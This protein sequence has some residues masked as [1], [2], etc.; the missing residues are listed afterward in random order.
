[1]AGRTYLIIGNGAL[2]TGVAA[3]LHL[4]GMVPRLLSRR[5][6]EAIRSRVEQ[7]PLGD[8][9]L[10]L[11]ELS[12][13]EASQAQAILVTVKAHQ[14]RLALLQ[15]LP[16]LPKSAPIISL[17]N[18][19]IDEELK[20]LSRQFP[21]RKFRWGTTTLAVTRLG[22]SVF[23][24]RNPKAT[25]TWGPLVPSEDD[26]LE[27]ERQLLTH[28]PSL[29]RWENDPITSGRR[30]WLFN[31]V[32]NSL[33]ASESAPTNGSLLLHRERLDILFQEAFELG[34]LHWGPWRQP[35]NELFEQLLD[36]IEKTHDNEN[37]MA[38]DIRLGKVTETDFLAGIARRYPGFEMLKLLQ[39][40][41]SG[42]HS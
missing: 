17:G 3:H 30:K 14:L 18:G 22:E 12:R 36:L 25:I 19:A 9:E 28:S 10:S 7:S 13:W 29:F 6:P 20:F 31:T 40:K 5:G 42:F 8:V 2:G 37:S 4:M 15:H 33:A 41:L 1:M 35:K 39:E 34:E 26:P 21:D 24:F 27:G 16:S 11:P 23:S 38:Q 32:L